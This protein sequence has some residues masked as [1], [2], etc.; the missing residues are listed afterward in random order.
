MIDCYL[1]FALQPDVTRR[2]DNMRCHSNRR[3]TSRDSTFDYA[4]THHAV[5]WLDC[6]QRH[7]R[8]LSAPQC[9]ILMPNPRVYSFLSL[10]LHTVIGIQTGGSL[11]INAIEHILDSLR[12]FTAF[13]PGILSTSNHDSL[14]FCRKASREALYSQG[15]DTHTLL[16]NFP[17]TTHLCPFL[18]G[19]RF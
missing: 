17:R 12:P 8:L 4:H 1:L 7:D 18:D 9:F 11:D 2:H 14:I 6:T 13:Q 10:P 19:Q 3:S 5:N 15:P 16:L